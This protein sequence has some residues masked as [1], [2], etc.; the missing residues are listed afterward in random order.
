MR[1]WMRHWLK[2]LALLPLLLLAG[3]AAAAPTVNEFDISLAD[4]KPYDI[5]LGPDGKLWFTEDGSTADKIGRVTPGNP[6]AIDLFDVPTDFADP[7]D[8][9]VAPDNKIWFTG[10]CNNAGGVGFINPA[11]TADKTCKG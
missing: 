1:H 5:V 2:T 3:P 7:G 8:I 6:P 10:K 11:N 4:A 9:A